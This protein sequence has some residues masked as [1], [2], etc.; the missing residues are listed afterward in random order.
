MTAICAFFTGLFEVIKNNDNATT[1]LLCAKKLCLNISKL[2]ICLLNFTRCK[3][4]YDMGKEFGTYIDNEFDMD[5]IM[6]IA[7]I[8]ACDFSA[9]YSEQKS[10]FF[11][12]KIR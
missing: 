12:I 4:M 3:K 11:K 2:Y 6:D 7:V 5:R 8:F 1:K 10:K 9:I